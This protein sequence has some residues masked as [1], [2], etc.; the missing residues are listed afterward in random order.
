MRL[1]VFYHCRLSGGCNVDTGA[2]IDPVFG[3]RLFQDQ[4]KTVVDSGLYSASNEFVI[5][6]NGNADCWT[7]IN[8]TVPSSDGQLVLYH[9][10]KS[11]SLLPTMRFLQEWLPG[12]EDWAVCFFH[13]K[14][15][16]HPNDPFNTAWRNCMMKHVITNWRAC[17]ADLEAGCDAAGCHWLHNSP[18]DPNADRWGGN[19]FF[20]GVFWWATARYLLT[21]PPLPE[22]ITDRHSWFLPELWLGNGR[23]RIK[24]YHAQFPNLAG[25]QQ[26][27]MR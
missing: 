5:G 6:V 15:A 27:A 12:H 19:S 9:G 20:G 16:T 24:D 22:K 2:S 3:M 1:A 8:A 26:S 10:E 18:N 17:V 13:S 25:C 11:Q 14:G 21:L 23:P 4:I 7:S